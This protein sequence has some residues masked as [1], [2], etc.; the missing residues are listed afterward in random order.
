MPRILP[1]ALALAVL[2]DPIS[3]G[4]S[5]TRGLSTTG[6]SEWVV[7]DRQSGLAIMGYDPVAYISAGGPVLGREA[8]ELVWS[9]AVW[10]FA[11]AA[12]MALFRDE[13]E[14]YAPRLGGYDPVAVMRGSAAPGHPRLF[15]VRGD[16]L[17][18]FANAENKASFTDAYDFQ[19]LQVAWQ[20]LR[21]TL[22][23]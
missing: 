4:A 13:P 23:P 3:A 17:Y 12:N 22:A 1:L 7:T 5:S 21:E 14:R 16:G 6:L 10:R 9:G 19:A 2:A 8:H 18:L 11:S 20:Q 15:E